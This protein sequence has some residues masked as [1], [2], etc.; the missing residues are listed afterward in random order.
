MDVISF[1]NV[2]DVCYDPNDPL[3]W[4]RDSLRRE[5]DRTF[6]LCNSCRMCF[7]YCTAFPRLFEIMD[8]PADGDVRNISEADQKKVIGE[9][10]QCKIC[11]VACPYTDADGHKYDLNFPALM[12]RAVNIDA[13]ENG[14]SFRSKVLQNPDMAGKMN[15]GLISRLV[16]KTM[17][18]NFHRKIMQAILGIHKDKKLPEFHRTSFAR[19]F[20]KYRKKQEQEH[21]LIADPVAKVVLFST[22]FVNYNN[23]SLGRDVVE[24]LE[25][26]R[27][28]VDCPEQNCCGMPALE[29]GDLKFAIKKMK[30]NVRLLLP[31]AKQGYKILA[32]NPTCSLTLKQEY[33]RFLPEKDRD[34]AQVVAQATMDLHEFLFE[35]KKD[36]KL[37]RD[38]LSSPGKVAYHVPC[39]L[40]AQNIGFRSRDVMKLVPES[41]I[42]VV[43][44]CCGHDGTWAM[45]KEYFDLSMTA[46]KRAFEGLSEQNADVVATDCPLAAIQLEQGMQA[47]TRP[48]HPIQVLARAYRRPEAGGWTK[49]IE[50][51]SR[52]G[53]S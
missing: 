21:T 43:A 13:R 22:C 45:K 11:Y 16:N 3:Y 44:D 23:P 12:Q 8:G 29:S 20:Q 36:D 39:H 51:N 4:D 14:I 5:V 26:N 37:N 27:V 41:Q 33:V 9:C 2:A 35:L 46:G 47:D 1:E 24:V 10:Y 31:Y 32:V 38:F 42:G 19:W 18:M 6:D 52:P 40:R 34:D 53:G 48:L 17:N 25:R 49:P 7:K 15:T 50:S 30:R 28:H